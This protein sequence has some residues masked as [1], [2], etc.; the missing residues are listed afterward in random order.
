MAEYR[1]RFFGGAFL[2]LG[3]TCRHFTVMAS[4]PLATGVASN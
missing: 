4:K 2:S 3:V 1:R